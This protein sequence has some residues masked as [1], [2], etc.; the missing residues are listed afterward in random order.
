MTWQ[1][2]PQFTNNSRSL[3]KAMLV[4]HGSL[5]IYYY[6]YTNSILT[7]LTFNLIVYQN[8]MMHKQFPHLFNFFL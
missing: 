2:T 8:N 4:R 6:V 5:I 3:A 1:I 7:D